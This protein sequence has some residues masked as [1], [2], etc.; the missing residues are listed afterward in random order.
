[1]MSSGLW[2]LTFVL[3]VLFIA[4]HACTFSSPGCISNV[5]LIAGSSGGF[6]NGLGAAARFSYPSGVAVSLSGTVFV[7]DLTNHLVRAISPGGLVSVFAGST[8]TGSSDG[9]GAAARFNRPSGVAVSLDDTVFVADSSNHKIRAITSSGL[10]STLA[11]SGASA[12]S[13]GQGAAA[14]FNY[15]WSVAVS[16]TALCSSPILSTI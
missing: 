15:P 1:M 5:V 13:N 6:A 8:A 4:S 10:V 14:S 16:S 9:Q 3:S 2:T 7:A 12:S 11:G